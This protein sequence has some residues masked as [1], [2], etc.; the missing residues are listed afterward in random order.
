MITISQVL[1]HFIGDYVLQSS[2]MANHKTKSHVP[3]LVHVLTYALPFLFLQPSW[4]ALFVIVATHFVID[5]WRL[6]RYFCWFKNFIGPFWKKTVYVPNPSMEWGGTDV[7]QGPAVVVRDINPS[8]RACSA[9][10]YSPD[11]PPFLAV[12]LL[13]IVDNVL[14]VI[15]NGLAL[16]Y[17]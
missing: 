11:T 12:W 8:W 16:R 6:A 1:C 15:I 9:T 13:I 14:H 7:V 4:L 5:R 2:W 3:A 17:L 10:G